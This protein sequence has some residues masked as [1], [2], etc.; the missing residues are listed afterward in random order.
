M[1]KFKEFIDERIPAWYL[2]QELW[3]R[4]KLEYGL[5]RSGIIDDSDELPPRLVIERC[6]R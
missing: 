3:D 2:D 5:K 1:Y 6:R 4:L